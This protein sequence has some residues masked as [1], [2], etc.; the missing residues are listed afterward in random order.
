M[1]IIKRVQDKVAQRGLLFAFRGDVNDKNSLSL[2]TLLENE[3]KEDAFSFTGRK[4]LFMYVLE[5][6]QNIVKH[7]EHK[8]DGH[9]SLVTYSKT[10]DGYRIVTGNLI[11]AA[12]VDSLDRKL[13]KVTS[14]DA[15]GIKALY[16]QIL[17]TS[18][19][20]E[21]GGA[22]LGLIEMAA[23]TGNKLEYGFEPVENDYSY[24]VIGKTVDSTGTGIYNGNRETVFNTA[25]VMDLENVMAENRIYMIWSG[26][27]TPGIGEEVLSI[28][29]SRLTEE[30]MGSRFR[31]RVFNIMVETLENMSK[32]NPGREAE[33]E[34][35]MPAAIVRIDEGAVILTTGNLMNNNNVGV[36][37]SILDSVNNSVREDLKKLFYSSL[38]RQSIENDSTGNMGLINIALKSGSRLQYDFRLV[39]ELYTYFTMTVRVDKEEG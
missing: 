14:L 9:M 2:L 28:T 6:L 38:S 31:R 25:S 36:L 16:K 20:S 15:E 33:K 19:F 24:F 10:D 3:M 23:K 13:R 1:D 21:K 22:G 4:R 32:Y 27:L 35:G 17:R 29:E 30:D 37:K 18:E 5:N 8:K 7:G 11:A 34:Y 39:N 26:H 12:Q